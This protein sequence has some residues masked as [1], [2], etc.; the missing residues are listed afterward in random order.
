MITDVKTIMVHILKKMCDWRQLDIDARN[1]IREKSCRVLD[2]T[3]THHVPT[4]Y[5]IKK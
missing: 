1:R 5:A 4:F 2:V 3:I